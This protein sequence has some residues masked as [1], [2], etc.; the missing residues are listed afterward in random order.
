LLAGRTDRP[1]RDFAIDP[2]TIQEFDV[3]GKEDK[4]IKL[5]DIRKRLNDIKR[6]RVPLMSDGKKKV[7]YVVH[8]QP[9]DTYLVDKP[10]N[11]D[12]TLKELLDSDTGKPIKTGLAFI[13]EKAT[14]AE[15]K[16][17]MESAQNCQDVFI[18]DTGDS[19][20]KVLGW[21]TNNEIRRALEP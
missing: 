7:R 16:T 5:L 8:Q 10:G 1:A 3:T 19:S 2:N 21:L 17:A 4:D 14:L 18:T 20:G 11:P 9:L 13:R 6:Y 12:A 15:A